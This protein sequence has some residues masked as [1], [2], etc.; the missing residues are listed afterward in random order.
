[1]QSLYNV[2]VREIIFN[3]TRYQQ[4]CFPLALRPSLQRRLQ[5]TESTL[6]G[7]SNRNA[8]AAAVKV[9]VC[10]CLCYKFLQPAAVVDIQ[11]NFTLSLCSTRVIT[12]NAPKQK[13]IQIGSC[14][15]CNH[16][17][18]FVRVIPPA[19]SFPREVQLFST[20][21]VQHHQLG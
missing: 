20:R 13:H 16:L 3:S 18:A 7:R 12:R 6:D 14:R 9:S 21:S 17:V 10:A 19:P 4:S 11:Y 8:Y 2:A 5:E 15:T 1:M